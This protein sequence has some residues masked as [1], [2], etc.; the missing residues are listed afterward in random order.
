MN[1]REAM[2]ETIRNLFSWLEEDKGISFTK[3]EI[4]NAVEIMHDDSQFLEEL[5]D[6]FADHIDMYGENYELPYP[7][8]D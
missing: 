3:E 4:D 5:L 6:W 2:K 8:E 7:E 1:P